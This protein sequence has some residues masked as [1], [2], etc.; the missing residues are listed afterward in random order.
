VIE[1]LRLNQATTNAAWKNNSSPARVW[2]YI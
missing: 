1:M 2:W